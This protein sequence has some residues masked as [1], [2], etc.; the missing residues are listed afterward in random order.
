MKI[1]E[2]SIVEGTLRT[3]IIHDGFEYVRYENDGGGKWYRNW[4]IVKESTRV[5]SSTYPVARS[6]VVQSADLEQM[7]K[8]TVRNGKIEKILECL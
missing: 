4:H 2:E 1:K 8:S 5:Q 3:I 7:Y 6:P